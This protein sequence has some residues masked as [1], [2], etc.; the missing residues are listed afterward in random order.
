MVVP[1]AIVRT[2]L[3]SL[4]LLLL[5]YILMRCFVFLLHSTF[6]I[7][8]QS[9]IIYFLLTCSIRGDPRIRRPVSLPQYLDGAVK[10]SR[11]YGSAGT[12]SEALLD[13]EGNVCVAALAGGGCMFVYVNV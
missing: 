11:R 9:I 2:V 8:I 12:Q 10:R 13:G 3:P 5:Q 1:A 7:H 6:Y 4:L